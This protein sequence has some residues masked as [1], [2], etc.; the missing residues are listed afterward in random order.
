MVCVAAPAAGREQQAGVRVLDERHSR[1][2]DG[3]RYP[4]PSEQTARGMVG[5]VLAELRRHPEVVGLVVGSFQGASDSVLAQREL[6]AAS[7]GHF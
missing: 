7:R 1:R 5:P 2:P 3:G 6:R 4:S